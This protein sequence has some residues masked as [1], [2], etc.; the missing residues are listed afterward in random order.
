MHESDSRKLVTT[1]GHFI[2]GS[3][4]QKNVLINNCRIEL[5]YLCAQVDSFDHV[6]VGVN[7]NEAS[8]GFQ[9]LA[10]KI[11]TRE[12]GRL[13][14]E[15]L[16]CSYNLSG[17]EGVNARQKYLLNETIN[18]GNKDVAVQFQCFPYYC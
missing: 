7:M 8:V 13:K 18:I 10:V 16:S 6:W 12:V 11:F 2:F 15:F 14:I 9:C 5:G 1:S 3:V 17:K 4:E